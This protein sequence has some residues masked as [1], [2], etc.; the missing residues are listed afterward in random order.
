M[1]VKGIEKGL[2]LG[3]HKRVIGKLMVSLVSLLQELDTIR[4][5]VLLLHPKR[6]R[7]DK[8]RDTEPTVYVLTTDDTPPTT[9]TVLTRLLRSVTLL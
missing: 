6:V 8:R 2:L 7:V 9:L 3:I 4:R 1:I 5:T